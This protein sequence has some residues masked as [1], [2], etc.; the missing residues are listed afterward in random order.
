MWRYCCVV[1]AGSSLSVS[2]GQNGAPSD[3]VARN[4]GGRQI[5][6][7]RSAGC[8][9]STSIRRTRERRGDDVGVSDSLT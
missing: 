9:M 2:S 7:S 6:Y 8:G 5:S 3:I 4:A 1:L